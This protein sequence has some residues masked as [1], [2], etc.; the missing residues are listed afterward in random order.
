MPKLLTSP[1][2]SVAGLAITLSLGSSTLA[3]TISNPDS[4]SK[5][6]SEWKPEEHEVPKGSKVHKLSQGLPIA[7][8][9]T[10][11]R[12]RK[13]IGR[14]YKG[15]ESSRLPHF[16]GWKDPVG[17]LRSWAQRIE[18]MVVT[19]CCKVSNEHTRG[20]CHQGWLYQKC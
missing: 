2:L 5:K 4:L 14:F 12:K 10:G 19:V 15:T 9:S 11:W 16:T 3:Q 17:T 13:R 20:C 6:T 7:A 1:I 18:P 8:F